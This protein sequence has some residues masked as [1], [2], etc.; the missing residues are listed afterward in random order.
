MIQYQQYQTSLS[1]NPQKSSTMLNKV[2]KVSKTP[3][4]MHACLVADMCFRRFTISNIHDCL[5]V[6]WTNHWKHG[7]M[8]PHRK[9]LVLYIN[10]INQILLT[11]SRIPRNHKISPYKTSK[12]ASFQEFMVP[13]LF[14]HRGKSHH[15]NCV[16]FGDVCETNQVT[17]E[18]QGFPLRWEP[19][20]PCSMEHQ[21]VVVSW[22]S[23]TTAA[24]LCFN[25]VAVP[26]IAKFCAMNE[27]SRISQQA[28][29]V[30]LTTLIPLQQSTGQD[31]ISSQPCKGHAAR[32]VSGMAVTPQAS[33][34]V[35]LRSFLRIG[36]HLL[37]QV[38]K[39]LPSCRCC[40]VLLVFGSETPSMNL[41]GRMHASRECGKIGKQKA[42]QQRE[43]LSGI[44]WKGHLW[45][46][47][48]HLAI[49][50]L[51]WH[52]NTN[53][54]LTRVVAGLGGKVDLVHG[55]L[56]NPQHIFCSA[57]LCTRC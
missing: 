46:K 50:H 9:K 13:F 37:I 21:Q 31:R 45:R 36:W 5:S 26:W 17:Q 35:P 55:H 49:I 28:H 16:V 2:G 44:C 23:D 18:F 22:E 20:A 19:S 27:A 56:H 11:T 30:C 57:V 33:P 52:P 6:C 4:R 24:V 10:Y 3:G 48:S 40:D 42:C 29:D 39:C 51:L 34:T 15:I 32:L 12:V 41:T 47:K 7:S 53:K 14:S 25:R 43:R 38:E 54:L 8:R 1:D